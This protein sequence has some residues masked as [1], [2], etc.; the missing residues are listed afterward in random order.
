MARRNRPVRWVK[1]A[2]TTIDHPATNYRTLRRSRRN[3]RPK[4]VPYVERIDQRGRLW[5]SDG[6]GG[7]PVCVGFV[8][9]VTEEK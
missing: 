6:G 2:M 5:I 3:P 7:P 1:V 9:D 8:P 4:Q